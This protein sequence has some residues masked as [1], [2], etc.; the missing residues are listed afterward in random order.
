MKKKVKGSLTLEF[1]LLLPVLIVI[2]LFMAQAG[3]FFYNRCL[4]KQNAQ[5]LALKLVQS[6]VQSL[7][8]EELAEYTGTLKQ[9]KYLLLKDVEMECGKSGDQ[10]TVSVGGRMLNFCSVAGLGEAYLTIQEEATCQYMDK[11]GVLGIIRS[12]RR[13]VDTYLEGEDS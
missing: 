9:Y 1:T 4:L 6:G 7:T 3:L 2:L 12:I 11:A 13:K 10:I 5:L 8:Q